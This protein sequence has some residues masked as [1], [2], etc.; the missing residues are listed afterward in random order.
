M[1][2]LENGTVDAVVDEIVPR[3]SRL[4]GEAVAREGSIVL[5]P[6]CRSQEHVVTFRLVITN[7]RLLMEPTVDAPVTIAG[8]LVLKLES[9]VLLERRQQSHGH[10]AT[11]GFFMWS[12]SWISGDFEVYS[13]R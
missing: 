7:L 5:V 6:R 4:A 10:R 11:V 12:T 2:L 9:I 8:P 1:L 13:N 3:V